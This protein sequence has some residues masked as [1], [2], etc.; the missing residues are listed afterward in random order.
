[1]RVRKGRGGQDGPSRVLYAVG[2]NSEANPY[3]T[4]TG[5]IRRIIAPTS[6]RPAGHPRAPRSL[7]LS[8]DGLKVGL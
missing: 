7:A 5:F 4:P 8:R 6:L 3:Y 1:M 2:I